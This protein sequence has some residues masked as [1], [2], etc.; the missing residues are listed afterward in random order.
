MWYQP[1][2]ESWTGQKQIVAWSAVSY[3]P[4]GAKEPALGTIKIEGPT[5]R[6]RSTT[7]SSR[8]DLKITEY[9]F[10]SLS[11]DQVKTLV[12]DVQALPQNER[13]LDL[14]RLLAYYRTARCRSRTSKAS[15]PI[16]RRCSTRLRLPCSSTW[17]AI[18]IWSP[19]KEVDLRYAVNTNWDLFE[20][21][22]SK[23]LYLRYNESWLR[24]AGVTGPWNGC[25]QASRELLEAASRRQLEGREGRRAGEE[26]LEQ[27]DP[28]G[29]R[30]HRAGRVDRPRRARSAT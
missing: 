11:P 1:Q 12:A 25:R 2:V 5:A 4:A 10:K 30:D 13:V 16:R 29:V 14:D 22:P 3:Q 9:N 20:H 17:M 24:S 6:R 7:A 15:K 21:T 23:T 19:I 26:A 18:A 28:E 27:D 8:M